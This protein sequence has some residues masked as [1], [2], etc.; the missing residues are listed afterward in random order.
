LHNRPVINLLFLILE[1]LLALLKISRLEEKESD[2]EVLSVKFE[3][4]FI[5]K[6][7]LISVV[8]YIYIKVYSS[9]STFSKNLNH[10]FFME[11]KTQQLDVNGFYF[12]NNKFSLSSVHQLSL[13]GL[14]SI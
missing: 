2:S 11:S 4:T 9:L 6:G 13:Y 5:Q 12:F 10:V 3:K 14:R 7:I 1:W 8:D